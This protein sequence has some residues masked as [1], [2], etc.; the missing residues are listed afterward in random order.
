LPSGSGFGEC[1]GEVLPAAEN[2]FTPEDEACNGSDPDECAPLANGWLEMYG[3]LGPA[4]VI[5]GVDVTPTGDIVAVGAFEDT[6]DF[7]NGPMASTGSFDIFVAKFDPFGKPIWSRRFGDA[8]WQSAYAVGVDST[9]AIYVGGTMSGAADF[10]GTVLT[11][12]GSNDAFLA[13][14]DPDGKVVWAQIHGDAVN[15]SIRRIEV[16]KTNLVVV[17]G[18]FYGSMQ[19]GVNTLTANGSSQD[20][21]VA[22]FDGSGFH[23]ASRAF[24]GPLTETLRGLALDSADRVYITGGFDDVVNFGGTTLTSTGGRDVFLAGLSSTLSSQ[25]AVGFGSS[26]VGTTTQ[27]GYD[28]AIT[29]A[30]QLWLAGGF[31]DGINFF[32]QKYFTN[33]VV[34]RAL[35]LAHFDTQGGF[36]ESYAYGG[37]AAPGASSGTISEARLAFDSVSNQLVVAGAFTG[38]LDFG[39]NA[40][41]AEGGADP[42]MAKLTVD[43]IGL[44]ASRS[45]RNDPAAVLDAANAIN[46]LTL[47]PTGDIVVGG[48]ERTPILYGDVIIGA[49]EPKDG[50]AM[51]GRFLP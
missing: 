21:F 25:W 11:S 35:F 45:L 30:D 10:D 6:I 27:E 26:T 49:S 42:F 2:C 38:Q 50:N 18:E 32:G 5:Y 36:V 48:L 44:V 7:V 39:G 34:S 43:P 12:A 46:A 19:L 17:G 14:L 28:I 22:R 51:L 29:P 15:Q 16:T 8:S 41:L 13:K 4:Q 37:I 3:S 23:S 20:V 33:E 47:L 1:V 31:V 40:M 24:G 9:G